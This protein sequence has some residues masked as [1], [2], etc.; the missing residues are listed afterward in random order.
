MTS[1][2]EKHSGKLRQ[3]IYIFLLL[4]SI[5]IHFNTYLLQFS[6]S[7]LSIVVR[8]KYLCVI[9]FSALHCFVLKLV[10]LHSLAP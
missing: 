5:F 6:L 7:S 10:R 4:T 1:E 9:Q 8:I 3:Q 2:D